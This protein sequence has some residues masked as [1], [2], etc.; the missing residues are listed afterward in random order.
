MSISERQNQPTSIA[1]LAAQRHLYSRAD[2]TRNIAL[3]I[4]LGTAILGIVASTTDI[5]HF[6]YILPS[7]V[8][9]SWFFDQRCLATRERGN[10]TE[11]AQIREAFDCYVLDLPWPSY[12]GLQRPTNDR[13]RQLAAAWTKHNN[14]EQLMNW[15][16]PSAISADPIL[17]KLDCQRMNCWWNINLREK[18]ISLWNG[19]FWA[20]LVVIVLL[21]VLT[22][23]TV[24]KCVVILASSIRLIAWVLN[25]YDSQK[26]AIKQLHDLHSFADGFR[27]GQIPSEREIRG[28][29]DA[30]FDHRRSVPPIPDWFYKW[31]RRWLEMEVSGAWTLDGR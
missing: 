18:W 23:L 26:E 16:T 12:R 7:F 25:E 31:H 5:K 6:T 9:L 15:Y 20:L 8:V 21:S 11:A 19:V 10:L 27:G 30:V 28:V 13:V 22:E 4:I 2:E 1:L 14:V 17:A 3:A 29:Q 24:A